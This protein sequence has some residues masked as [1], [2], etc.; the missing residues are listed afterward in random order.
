METEMDSEKRLYQAIVWKQDR[1]LPGERTTI[2]A[3]SLEDA[4]RQLREQYGENIAFSLYSE[5]E[6]NKAR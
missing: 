6:A 4:A 1:E 2:L 5:E 3:N